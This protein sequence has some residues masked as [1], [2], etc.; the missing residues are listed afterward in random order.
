MP[1]VPTLPS[2]GCLKVGNYGRQLPYFLPG[3]KSL[4][5]VIGRIR[6]TDMNQWNGEYFRGGRHIL[7]VVFG[8]TS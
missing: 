7:H 6:F 2:S 3:T 8:G 5:V 4:Q 1:R